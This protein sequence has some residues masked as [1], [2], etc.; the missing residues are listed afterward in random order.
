MN[1][2]WLPIPGYEG[3]Y[4]V[5][6][7]G[8]VRSLDRY[9]HRRDKAKSYLK[10]GRILKPRPID[11]DGGRYQVILCNECARTPYGVHVLVL[12]TF[13]CIRPH[14]FVGCHD[15]GDSTNNKLSNLYWGTVRANMDDREYHGRTV[16]GLNVHSVKLTEDEVRQIRIAKGTNRE[17][18]AKFNIGETQA[19]SIRARKKWKHL[20]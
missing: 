16:K 3:I 14:G 9:I 17:I 11:K 5:S 19:W 13:L 20:S 12:M 8:R 10:S 7:Q 1:E 6:D 18:A 4:E 15:D 2:R